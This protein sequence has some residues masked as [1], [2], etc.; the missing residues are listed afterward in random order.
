MTG[1]ESFWRAIDAVPAPVGTV[2]QSL[3]RRMLRE[4]GWAELLLVV[5]SLES[6]GVSYWLA[7]GWGVDALLGRCTR[8]HKDIDII[9]DDFEHNEPKARQAFR[10]LGFD[11]VTTDQGGVWM[12]WR[13]NF[14]DRAGH[15][16]EALAIDWGHLKEVFALAP[17][18]EPKPTWP[19]EDLVREI[20][21]VGEI[22]GR[23]VPCLTLAAQ[24]LFHTGFPLEAS[25]RSDVS[26]LRSEFGLAV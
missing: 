22:E 24:L 13:S 17:G 15:R 26:L 1:A 16:I 19:I 12:P 5:E 2:L 25:G 23:Q 21:T 11:H 18:G 10:S 3:K 8:R 14:E 20:L 9:I 4:T 7:G 6:E